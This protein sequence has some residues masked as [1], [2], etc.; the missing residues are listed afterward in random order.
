MSTDC[1]AALRGVLKQL[2]SGSGSEFGFGWRPVVVQVTV[3]DP[4]M[5]GWIEQM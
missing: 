2:A 3:I 5:F 4:V 1:W